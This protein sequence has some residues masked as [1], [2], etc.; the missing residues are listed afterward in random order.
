VNVGN[1]SATTASPLNLGE[2]LHVELSGAGARVTV[3][4]PVLVNTGVVARMGIDA[5]PLPAGP[6]SAEQTV[7]QGFTALQER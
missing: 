2:A 1:D 6:V 3:L 4:V 7:E 5:V